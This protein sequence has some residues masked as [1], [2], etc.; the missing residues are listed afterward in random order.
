MS[1]E[2]EIQKALKEKKALLGSRSVLSAARVGKI[3]SLVYARNTPE[4]M[5]S[6]IRHFSNV[7][8][9]KMHEFEGNSLEL[10]EL[11]GKPFSV[12]LLGITK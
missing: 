10:G 6:D 7:S 4:S 9:I 1:L 12:L 8:G 2:K 3:E 5:I 11:C